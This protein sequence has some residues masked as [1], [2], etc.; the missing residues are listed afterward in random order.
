[1]RTRPTRPPS[2]GKGVDDLDLRVSDRHLADGVD[3]VTVDEVDEVVEQSRHSAP[4][5]SPRYDVA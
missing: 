2:V 3:V 5:S 1:M 4:G